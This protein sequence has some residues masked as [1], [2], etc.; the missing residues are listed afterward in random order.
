[1]KKHL[2][3]ASL[4]AALWAVSAVASAAVADLST[5]E[6]IEA[7]SNI[8]FGSAFLKD[9]KGSYFSDRF[10][11][12]TSGLSSLSLTVSTSFVLP[13]TGLDLTDFALFDSG[14]HL[15]AQGV[16]KMFPNR[17]SWTLTLDK[18]AAGNYYLM[19][20]GKLLSNAGATFAGTGSA[21]VAPPVPEPATYAMLG[22]GLVLI[23][24]AARRRHRAAGALPTE[25]TYA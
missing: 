12:G 17:E 20:S 4:S 11:F 8:T 9:Q 21:A 5:V 6:Q 22:A 1:M 15:I 10:T 7:D 13:G 23:L 24:I 18:L 14:N 16:G 3:S 2:L 25:V 19:V